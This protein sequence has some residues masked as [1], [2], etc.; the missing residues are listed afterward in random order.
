MYPRLI[1]N[2][3]QDLKS[4]LSDIIGSGKYEY[5]SIATGY[6]DLPGMVDI[7]DGLARFKGIRLLIGQEPLPHR[8]Q[9]SLQLNENDPDALFPDKNFAFDLEQLGKRKEREVTELRS[10]ARK[11]SALMKEGTLEV[12][13]FRN[14]R[15]HAKAY[16]FGD[17]A[18]SEA[19]GIIGS[20]NFTKAGLTSNAELNWLEQ[21]H[22]LV[23]YQPQNE[24]QEHGH[25]SWFNE[26]WE[27][28]EAES[29]TGTFTEILEKSPV[30]DMMYGPYDVYI[31]TLM[32]VFPDEL[33]P[34]Q[35]L[36]DDTR[37]ILFAFQDRNAGILL[38]KL[39]KMGVAMLSDSVGLGKTVT[40]GAVIKHYRES[41]AHRVL[42]IAPSALK[43][44][45]YDDLGKHFGLDSN[46]FG[47]ISMQHISK[48]ERLIDEMRKPWVRE[49]DLFVIDEAHNLRSPSSAR[50]ETILNLLDASPDAPVLLLTATPINNSL[51]DFANQI[52]LGLRGSM[53]SVPV[54]YRSNDGIVQSIDF[55]D[56]LRL[57]Q[58]EA[59]KA[60]KEG[61][62]FDWSRYDATLRSGLRHYLVRSTRQGVEAEGSLRKR[63]V[64]QRFPR[65]TVKQL[66]YRY[67]DAIAENAR[68]LCSNAQN[69]LF[70][71]IDPLR[72][73]LDIALEITQQTMHPFDLF[74]PV[75][76]GKAKP[77]A[78]DSIDDSAAHM[79]FGEKRS[80][81][82]IPSVFQ[83]INFLGFVPYRPDLYRHRYYGKTKEQIQDLGL[84]TEERS[85][86]ST[87][88][89]IHNILHV[90]WLKRLESSAAALLKSVDYYGK[91]LDIFEKY[92]DKGFIVSLADA[93]ELESEYGE[94]LER[95]FSDY[96]HSM[97]AIQAALDAGEDI[98]NMKIEG[99]ERREAS[100]Q[101]YK[102]DQIRKDISR[103]RGILYLL[104]TILQHMQ[105][106]DDS[107]KI[108]AFADEIKALISNGEH[109]RK[110]LVFSFFA[111]TI[112]YLRESM[113]TL[114]ADVPGF[115]TRS[116]FLTG[117]SGGKTE[118]IACRFAPTAKKY[119]LKDG[120]AEIDY[121]FA[122][123]ILSEGQNLQDAGILINY[124]LHW[125]PVRM[126]QR[127]GR[128]NRLGSV[129]EDVQIVNMKPHD[130][131]ELYLNLVRRLERKIDT[132]KNSIGTDQ[133]V[134]GEQENPIEFADF[135]NDDVATASEAAEAISASSQALDVFDCADEYVFELRCFL[136]E[137]GDD[138]M[139]RRIEA[140][141]AGKWN[142]L[143]ERDIR[144]FEGEAGD[145]LP[146]DSYLALERVEGHSV[147]SNEPFNTTMFV[148][149]TAAGRYPAEIVE[150]VDA[151]ALIKTSPENN[152]P[153]RDTINP[154]LS[155]ERISKRANRM[156]R[157]RA[158]ATESLRTI[159]PSEQKALAAIQPYYPGEIDLQGLVRKGIRREQDNREFK[160]VVRLINTDMKERG[161]VT[162]STNT[163]FITLMKKLG[164]HVAE[165]HRADTI[166]D[167]LFYATKG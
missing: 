163:R 152:E 19:V 121:L 108:H 112:D 82:L 116:A 135:Y 57:I 33:L 136:N 7:I 130:D 104:R 28:E 91:R 72:L 100:Q 32:E 23:L 45:W 6:W 111:D 138:E 105:S 125:N 55:I 127:N 122:T 159:R 66:S 53:T 65:T 96:E 143:P 59:K 43:Q 48:Q 166:E 109:G 1:D 86:I 5:L 41:G 157:V 142:Y 156:A 27:D 87:Q 21:D 150:E 153:Q 106:S 117:S 144:F 107:G 4:V 24:Q 114:M 118:E 16:I 95:A 79:L 88:R 77:A 63:G 158:E 154:S 162:S 69:Q 73:N 44:Q 132:I 25:L 139:R 99:I 74:A 78:L 76:A 52:Q 75:F 22:H 140:M 42:V 83:I 97:R 31:K 49:V 56:A 103:D 80:Q 61:V 128:I 62:E 131:L 12:K 3:R 93:A 85:R 167:V 8:F 113:P 92:L 17:M 2:K 30:G 89:T 133:S 101:E 13:V 160:K 119:A 14:P 149:V 145:S 155:R 34:P 47:V 40:A 10:V 58:A 70:E 94:D 11:L 50:Y 98:T 110:V 102:I 36:S 39:Q 18:A 134:L 68:S 84:R 67:A 60:E 129:Y 151:L 120:E 64:Q 147:V 161:V 165:E 81:S 137:H 35:Q 51:M 9:K 126:I 54:Q 71:G 141:P 90:T 26:M 123:D 15:L 148:K 146:A 115:K 37:D 29:W 46:D 38:N 20:S 124:D 164:E